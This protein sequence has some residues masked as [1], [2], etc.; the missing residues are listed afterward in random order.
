MAQRVVKTLHPVLSPVQPGASSRTPESVQR[1][2]VAAGKALDGSARLCGVDVPT[3][4]RDHEG[5]PLPTDGLF[6]SISHKSEWAGGVVDDQP[7]GIDVECVTPRRR[8]AFA[9]AAGD[10]EWALFD[11]RNWENFFRLWTAKEAVV[12]AVTVGMAGFDRCTV[13][14]VVDD[15]EMTLLLDG[16]SWHVSH[17]RWSG[18]IAAVAHHGSAIQWHVEDDRDR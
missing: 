2:R 9:E 16:R 4:K 3:W 18:H 1:Q 11:S 6:W 13:E 12:K 8:E 17:Y 14:T 7:V 5:K 15:T 10:A